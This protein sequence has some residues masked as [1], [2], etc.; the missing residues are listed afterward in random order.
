[1]S[2][3]DNLN[4]FPEWATRRYP[5]SLRNIINAQRFEVNEGDINLSWKFSEID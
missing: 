4:E 5:D 3:N 2:P 1:M